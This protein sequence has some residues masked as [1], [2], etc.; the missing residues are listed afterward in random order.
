MFRVLAENILV[1][2]FSVKISQIFK[3]SATFKYLTLRVALSQR[4][5][6]IEFAENILVAVF[7]I[8][9][10]HKLL[11]QSIVENIT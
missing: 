2:I 10:Y 1:A 11:T 7:Y 6:I 5:D 9:Y 8:K 4:V 3:F